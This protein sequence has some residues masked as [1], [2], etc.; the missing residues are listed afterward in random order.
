MGR[1]ASTKNRKDNPIKKQKWIKELYPYLRDKGV[2]EL[3]MDA[4]A[5]Y[6]GKSK[7][8]VYEYFASKEEIIIGVIA[9]KLEALLGFEAILM[10][11]NDSLSHRYQNMMAHIIPIISDISQLLLADIKEYYPELWQKIDDFYTY[12]GEILLKFYQEGME[13]GT[14]LQVNPLIL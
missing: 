12:A 6:L 4:I 11:P 9:L 10:N 14:F 1:K 2:R 3:R 8:T 5:K 7:S 13:D